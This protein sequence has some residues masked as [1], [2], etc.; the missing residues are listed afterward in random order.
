MEYFATIKYLVDIITLIKSRLY[1][2]CMVYFIKLYIKNVIH[3][4]R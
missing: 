2:V 1:T 4:H 3:P